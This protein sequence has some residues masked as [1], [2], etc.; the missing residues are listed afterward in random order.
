MHAYHSYYKKIFTF[1]SLLHIRMSERS[2]NF[3]DK[4]TKKVTFTTET[5]KYLK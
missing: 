5:K 3:D 2:V 4:K 1:F